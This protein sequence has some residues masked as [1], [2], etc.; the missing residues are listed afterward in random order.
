VTDAKCKKPYLVGHNSN[1]AGFYKIA[2][3]AQGANLTDQQWTDFNL[4]TFFCPSN[5][6]AADRA[7][8]NTSVWRFQYNADWDNTRL[9]P[10]SGAYHGSE[11]NMIYGASVDVTGLSESSPQL[12]LQANM[13]KAWAAFITDPED[14]LTNLGWP[15]YDPQGMYYQPQ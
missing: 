10:T 8:V 15:K 7:S 11:L 14:G 5:L 13:Q 12:Q 3:F 6:E 4:Q 2:S 1:E 9:Y